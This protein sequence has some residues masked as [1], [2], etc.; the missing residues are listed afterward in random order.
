M[1]DDRCKITVFKITQFARLQ[2]TSESAKNEKITNLKELPRPQQLS[3]GALVESIKSGVEIG[4]TCLPPIRPL[5]LS[6]VLKKGQPPQRH[7]FRTIGKKISPQQVEKESPSHTDT[8]LYGP[9]WKEQVIL[10]QVE[11]VDGLSGVLPPQHVETQL[12]TQRTIQI[13]DSPFEAKTGHAVKVERNHRHLP[14]SNMK[15][16]DSIPPPFNE[17]LHQDSAHKLL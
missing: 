11:V 14:L 8:L 6:K 9:L 13:D 1:Q 12:N 10:H 17:A 7:H 5:C 3:Q 15:G 2:A 4:K 16:V